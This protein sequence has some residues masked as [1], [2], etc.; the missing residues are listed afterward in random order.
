M[1]SLATP[2]APGGVIP[3]HAPGLARVLDRTARVLDV[4]CRGAVGIATFG[5]VVAALTAMFSLASNVFARYVLGFS[6]FGAE[7]VARIAFLWTIWMGV[8]LA[9]R[10]GAVTVITFVADRGAPAWRRAVRTFSGL[11]LAILLVY[12]CWRSTEYAMSGGVFTQTFAASRISYFYPV[13]SMAVGYYFITLFTVHALTRGAADLAAAGREGFREAGSLMLGGA[14]LT[15]AVLLL[16]EQGRDDLG[17]A[18]NVIGI[19][20]VAGAWLLSVA[21]SPRSGILGATLLGVAMFAIAEGL[22]SGGASK[23]VAIGFLF[24]V[25]TL[26]GTPIVFMLSIVGIIAS[27]P[28][29][30]GLSFYPT[31]DP[32]FPFSTTQFTM[33]LSGGGELIVILMFLIIAEVLNASGLSERL[34]GFA[35]SLVGH[36]RGGM[37]YVCQLTSVMVSGVSGSAQ[38]DAAIMTPLLVP[39]MERE[40]YPRPVAAAVVSAA[41]IK[42][43][44]GPISLMFIVYAFVVEGVNLSRLLVSGILAIIVLFCFQAATVYVEVRVRGFHKQ[45]PFAGW[46]NVARRTLD[47]LPV[48]AIPVLVLGGIF[49]SGAFT[50]SESAPVAAV[51]AMVLALF[52]YSGL[53]PRDLPRAITLAGIETGI[54]LLLLGDSQI[55]A[56]LLQNNQFGQTVIDFFTGITDNKYVFLLLVNLILL[57]VG[58]FIEPLPAVF[59]LA[60]FLHPLAVDVY[61]MDP[62]HFALI[63]CF[64]LVLALIHPPIG[65]VLFL[66]SSLAKVSVERLSITILPWL[67]VSILV[68]FLMTYLP[69]EAVLVLADLIES[70]PDWLGMAAAVVALTTLAAYVP[71][72]LSL[73]KRRDLTGDQRANWILFSAITGAIGVLVYFIHMTF[74]RAR[75]AAAH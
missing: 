34:I 35:A 31:P 74:S 27:L 46:G 33:G 60:P 20:L 51:F 37:A 36:L 47:T 15:A 59:I 43:P 22:L 39:A 69:S 67:G 61:G 40:G 54:V 23:L 45:R 48:L 50:P 18:R 75:G 21:V 29:F 71:F 7:E 1:T 73:W 16:A 70:P 2:V 57:A 42:G 24:V 19:A 72:G 62:E 6:I 17:S 68:L 58:I 55:L 12:A 10:R 66:V 38:A 49:I 8:S 65:L 25:L 30:F 28:T 26:A 13:A 3:E 56:K 9:V 32:L 53:S 4:Y 63:V 11:A 44:I 41:S 5:T 14:A 64:N 52:W